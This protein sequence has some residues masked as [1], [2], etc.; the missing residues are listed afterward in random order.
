MTETK[1]FGANFRDA[2]GQICDT[3]PIH[4]AQRRTVLKSFL[5]YYR[6]TLWNGYRRQGIAFVKRRFRNFCELIRQFDMLQRLTVKEGRSAN[7]RDTG[8]QIDFL[9]G[10]ARDKSGI[11]PPPDTFTTTLLSPSYP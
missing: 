10:E 5:T 8:W 3:I 4:A 11:P 6:D 9:Q 1:R 2:V 7:G